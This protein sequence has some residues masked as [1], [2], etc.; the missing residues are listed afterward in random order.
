M[1]R[2]T[3]LV[4]LLAALIGVVVVAAVLSS[5]D[6]GGPASRPEPAPER[7]DGEAEPA[8]PLPPMPDVPDGSTGGV[9][10]SGV[11][12]GPDGEP[13]EG[14]WVSLLGPDVSPRRVT[15]AAGGRFEFRATGRLLTV[16]AEKD[17]FAPS[18]GER[19]GAKGGTGIVLTLGLSGRVRGRVVEPGGAA[20]AGAAVSAGEAS[21]LTGEDG[22]FDLT[23]F[24]RAERVPVEAMA[25]GYGS[26]RAEAVLDESGA[27][28]LAEPLVLTPKPG[29]GGRVLDPEGKPLEGVTVVAM[30]GFMDRERM[31]SDAAG[32]W[33]IGKADGGEWSVRLV[34]AEYLPEKLENVRAEEGRRIVLPDVRLRP[35]GEI[36]GR[37]TDPEGNP[38]GDVK[39]EAVPA[40][41]SADITELAV[42]AMGT[43]TRS[44]VT[45]PDGAYRVAGRPDGEHTL[46]AV[47]AGYRLA[48]REGIVVRV[49]EKTTVDIVLDRGNSIAGVVLDAAGAP[50]AGATVGVR[51]DSVGMVMR[52]GGDFREQILRGSW[53]SQAVTGG[54]GRFTLTGFEEEPVDISVRAPGYAPG[55]AAG[56]APG[57]RDLEIRLARPGRITGT[58]VDAAT[59]APVEGA[60]VSVAGDSGRTDAGGRFDLTDVK[61]GDQELSA[62]ADGYVAARLPVSVKAGEETGG[63]VVRMSTGEQLVVIVT[64]AS[65]GSP[66]EG[67]HVQAGGAV[68]VAASPGENRGTDAQGMAVVRGLL[69]GPV[70]VSVSADGLAAKEVEGVVVPAAEPLRVALGLG[71]TVRVRVLDDAG[72]PA[73]GRMVLL[74]RGG[75]MGGG[76][77]TDAE[78]RTTFA[79]VE[80]GEVV[81]ALVAFDA[82]GGFGF[83]SRTRKVMVVEGEDVSVEFGPETE[84]RVKLSGRL[85]D[86]GKP[87]SGRMVI[88]LPAEME[89]GF[90]ELMGG[91]KM[92][93]TD[94]E[95]RFSV[96]RLAPGRYW[97][98][99]GGMGGEEMGAGIPVTIGEGG[100]VRQDFELPAG[101]L[102]GKVTD[103]ETGAAV[104]GAK[105]LLLDAEAARRPASGISGL[106]GMVKGQGVAGRDGAYVVENAGLGSL[107]VQVSGEGFA[108]RL[109]GPLDLSAEGLTLDVTLER[110]VK[111]TVRVRGPAGEAVPG[112]D[113]ILFDGEGY[114]VMNL[115]DL[116]KTT[117]GEGNV[118][119]RLQRGS[120]RLVVQAAGHAPASERV[121]AGRDAEVTVPVSPGGSVRVIAT[122]GGAPVADARVRVFADGGEEIVPHAT[123]R[124]ITGGTPLRRTGADGVLLVEHLPPGRLRVTAETATGRRASAEVT[125]EEG[126]TA[127]LPL[128]LR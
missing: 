105:V 17:G 53:S 89:G 14:A 118:E 64:R 11:V 59:E 60:W 66:V 91:L 57:T 104:P 81:V 62:S 26:A 10:V 34:H 124:T 84:V 127:D 87:V 28:T 48:K 109:L 120:H 99:S 39:V 51:G 9:V 31:T 97:L 61:P 4:L 41:Q 65:D 86:R 8:R 12:L 111:L 103:A 74:G 49:P 29:F 83:D 114:R 126:A 108:A 5:S 24:A 106:L 40:K 18:E 3:G 47:A 37:V 27:A 6:P 42:L 22:G 68:P 119:V 15:T 93:N 94:G 92:V 25:A 43:D 23:G 38:V 98:M 69:P 2:V 32:R 117:D 7:P 19:V 30:R 33:W 50:V 116:N 122:S 100:D 88:L 79:H 115:D 80:P 128:P 107:V 67:A 121:T 78:G 44:R 101:R 110:G 96:D 21:V 13:V 55:E 58:V 70:T 54:D 36:V 123:Q 35:G 90:A 82:A 113:V 102:A 95:G 85:L 45:G 56:V 125:I 73:G 52:P 112:A 20:V 16:R 46:W 71:G 63:V 1:N 76:Q 75:D 77:Q 72:R